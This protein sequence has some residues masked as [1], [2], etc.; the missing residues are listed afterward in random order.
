MANPLYPLSE[1]ATDR[2]QLP[3]GREPISPVSF[4]TLID[5][6]LARRSLNM[7]RAYEKD[8]AGFATYL[9]VSYNQAALHRL[10]TAGQG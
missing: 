8:L 9:Q 7:R 10:V 5:G 6:F 4:Q 2:Q 3:L 1:W